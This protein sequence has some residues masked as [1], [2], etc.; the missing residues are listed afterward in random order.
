MPNTG[1]LKA[2]EHKAC[3]N[4]TT[5]SLISTRTMISFWEY[6]VFGLLNN[7]NNWFC[8]HVLFLQMGVIFPTFLS[9]VLYEMKRAL[10]YFWILCSKSYSRHK[11]GSNPSDSPNSGQNIWAKFF[12]SARKIKSWPKI[13]SANLHFSIHNNTC[14]SRGIH[15]LD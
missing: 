5:A 4:T 14:T 8:F 15:C 1:T 13:Y 10:P 6:F 2:K 12:T 11:S 3:F 7:T 9:V